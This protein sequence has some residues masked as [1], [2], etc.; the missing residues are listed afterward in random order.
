LGAGAADKKKGG[1]GPK[2]PKD[3]VRFGNHAFLLIKDP[4]TW[5]VAKQRCEELGGHLAILRTQEELDFALN[6]CKAG[7]VQS[8]W[9]GATDEVAE[10]K[11]KWV[12]GTDAVITGRTIDN[13]REVEHYAR[14]Y[15]DVGFDDANTLRLAYICEW[16]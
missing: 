4:A 14:V 8:A 1:K 2:A 6:M 12:D 9:I 3:A 13:S 15:I 10:G 16:D 7:G 11:W 5:H